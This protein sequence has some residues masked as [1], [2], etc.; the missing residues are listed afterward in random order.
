MASREQLSVGFAICFTAAA[1]CLRTSVSLA[2]EDAAPNRVYERAARKTLTVVEM[3]HG[4]EL[5]FKLRGGEERTFVLEKTS[6][7][8]IER[9]RGGIIYSFDCHLRADG[10]PLLLRRYVCSQETF[11]EPWVLNGVRLWLSSSKSVFQL[12][13]MRYPETHHKLDAD[14]IIVLQDAT[15]PICP[16]PMKLWFSMRRHFI[17]V[18]T[19]YNGDD[20]MAR[21]LLGAGL[22][23]GAGHQHVQGNSAECTD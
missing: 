15:M 1:A 3:N 21:P 11:Y 6:A 2:A 5:R 16:Q 4:D 17:D 7:R 20:R 8:I 18:G 14:A 23:C 19:C 10:Q 9:P 13:P 22:S 12:V